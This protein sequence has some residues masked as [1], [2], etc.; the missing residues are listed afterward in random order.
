M[1]DQKSTTIAIDVCTANAVRRLYEMRCSGNGDEVSLK[2]VIYS[3]IE[4][5][6]TE[7]IRKL[8]RSRDNPIL[9]DNLSKGRPPASGIGFRDNR[10]DY[11][12]L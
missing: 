3:V 9:K 7:E 4:E 10:A 5:G 2:T 8:R 11:S 6:L 1:S 12:K